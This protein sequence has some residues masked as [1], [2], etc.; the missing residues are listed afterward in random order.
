MEPLKTFIAKHP[1]LSGVM[2]FF[3]ILLP[4]WFEAIWALFTDKPFVQVL[5]KSLP[6]DVV[7][8][9]IQISWITASIG[10]LMLLYVIYLTRHKPSSKEVIS[11]AP[12]QETEKGY[13]DFSLDGQKA[14]RKIAKIT[15]KIGKQHTRATNMMN[16]NRK[17]LL[18]IQTWSSFGIGINQERRAY[19][20]WQRISSFVDVW[21]DEVDDLISQQKFEIATVEES[22]LGLIGSEKITIT[23]NDQIVFRIATTSGLD[24]LEGFLQSTIGLKASTK[25][26]RGISAPLNSAMNRMSGVL[27]RLIATLREMIRVFEKLL[28]S[29]GSDKSG[30]NEQWSTPPE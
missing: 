7:M 21:C 29:L 26:L 11:Q 19:K 10:F 15:T 3:V 2:S 6:G 18:R 17:K 9:Q 30:H 25:T 16:K 27:D 13:L 5:S 4:Q 22:Y 24:A 23:E 8:P 12:T 20:I 1:V 14:L 28:D